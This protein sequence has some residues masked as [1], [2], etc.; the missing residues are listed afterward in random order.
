[1]KQRTQR[2]GYLLIKLCKNGDAKH[3][4]VH[5]IVAETFIPNPQNKSQV[6][7]INGNKKDNRIEN[8]EWA[9]MSENIRHAYK[10]NLIDLEL[11][12][13]RIRAIGRIHKGENNNKWKGFINIYSKKGQL[14]A[15]CN[16]L[17][18][19]ANWVKEN[20]KYKSPSVGNICTYIKKQKNIYGFMF[21]YCKEKYDNAEGERTGGFGS[22]GK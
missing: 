20:T 1:M 21:K 6:N 3:K 13:E 15:Q 5:R 17:N 11:Q 19:T 2:N 16:T 10:N 14:V 7:H 8:L 9:T 22:T 18:E 12:K 4:S